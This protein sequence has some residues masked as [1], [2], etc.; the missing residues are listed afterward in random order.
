MTINIMMIRDIK[1]T[2]DDYYYDENREKIQSEIIIV[3][4]KHILTINRGKYCN[5]QQGKNVL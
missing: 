1:K 5:D 3:T 4:I 2:Q